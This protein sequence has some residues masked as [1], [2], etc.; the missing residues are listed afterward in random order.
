MPTS[1]PASWARKQPSP[2]QKQQSASVP[3]NVNS[4]TT[5]NQPNPNKAQTPAPKQD[6][7]LQEKISNASKEASIPPDFSKGGRVKQ[8]GHAHVHKGEV[9]F[10]KADAAHL[11]RTSDILSK[12]FKR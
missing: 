9:V 4:S 12:A 3:Q 7:Q 5:M 8:I 6:S 11:K 2:S 10:T 1:T